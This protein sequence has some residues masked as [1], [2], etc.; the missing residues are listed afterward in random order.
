MA[1]DLVVKRYRYLKN[2]KANKVNNNKKHNKNQTQTQQ[3]NL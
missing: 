2:K 3:T 1:I